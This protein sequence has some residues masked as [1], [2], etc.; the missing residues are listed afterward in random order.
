[1]SALMDAVSV[2]DSLM[3]KVKLGSEV[4]DVSILGRFHSYNHVRGGGDR[5]GR[6]RCAT[7]VGSCVEATAEHPPASV[8]L[9]PPPSWSSP[10]S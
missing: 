7:A 8:R 1:M 2:S 6:R 4:T 3:L 9:L 10:S 5:G